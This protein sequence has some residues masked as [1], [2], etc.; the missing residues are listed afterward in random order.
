MYK[1][2][3]SL[4]NI[5]VKTVQFFFF[6]ILT[7]CHTKII[8]YIYC[9]PIRVQTTRMIKSSNYLLYYFV[10]VEQQRRR[11]WFKTRAHLAGDN[12]L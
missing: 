8:T 12:G 10:S 9:P 6:W 7:F 4:K 1:I 3:V 5:I 2:S 11:L